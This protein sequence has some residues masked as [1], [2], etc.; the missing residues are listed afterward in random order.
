MLTCREV[1]EAASDH[2]SGDDPIGTRVS[3]TLHLALCRDCRAYVRSL[4]ISRSLTS[5]S[6]RG[7]IPFTLFR[8]VGPATTTLAGTSEE[9]GQ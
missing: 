2:I 8:E 4:K 1:S 6:L 9:T 7:S 5:E 3:V